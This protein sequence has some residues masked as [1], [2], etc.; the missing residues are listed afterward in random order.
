LRAGC[1]KSKKGQKGGNQ[2]KLPAASCGVSVYCRAG[3]V[4]EGDLP[5]VRLEG[6]VPQPFQPYKLHV[7]SNG[8]FDPTLRNGF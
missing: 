7:A 1:P 4:D 5:A 8:V 3:T 2:L 6:I